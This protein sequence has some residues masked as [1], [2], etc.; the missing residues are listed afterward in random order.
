[1]KHFFEKYWPI[2]G[3]VSIVTLI[4]ITNHVPNAFLTGGDNL[5]PE[6][7]LSENIKRSI[8]SVWQEY[9]GVGLLAGMGHASD[10]LRQL[11]L[12]IF[13]AIMPVESV[14]YFYTILTLIIGSIGSYFLIFK[15]LH[16]EEHEENLLKN[17][18]V[19]ITGAVFYLLNLAT[20]QQYF[21]AFEVFTAHFAALPFLILTAVNYFQKPT[22]KNLFIAG[23]ISFLASPGDYVPTL[24]IVYLMAASIL[25]LFLGQKN[26]L[27]QTFIKLLKYLLVVF[28]VNSFW[29]LPFI[30]FVLTNSNVVTNSQINRLASQTIFEQNKEF[31]DIFD[32]M[33][34]KGFW[35]N[36]VEPNT[37]GTFVYM[38]DAWRKYFSNPFVNAIGFSFFGVIIF[39]L[40]QTFRKSKSLGI[41]F[42]SLFVFSFTMLTTAT[43]PFSWIVAIMRDHLPLF[44]EVFRFPFTKFSLL[45]GLSYSIFFSIGIKEI[46]KIAKLSKEKFYFGA[47]ALSVF[48]I[49][50]FAL[51]TFRGEFFYYREQIQIP[52]YY[53]DFFNYLNKQDPSI[54][55]SDFPQYQNWE[56]NFYDWGYS[57]S[58]FVWYGIKQPILSRTFD[59]WSTQNE[60]YYWEIT[61]AMYAKNPKLFEDVLNKYQVS[62][63]YIDNSIQSPSS[64]KGL[65][66][67]ELK[68]II[69]EDKSIK[70]EKTFG[71]IELYSHD[72]SSNQKGFIYTKSTLPKVNSYD[73]SSYDY[74][75]EDFS[76]YSSSNS[77]NG[78]IYYPFRSSLFSRK[79]TTLEDFNLT[80]NKDYLE[81]S[82]ELP[83]TKDKIKLNLPSPITKNNTLPITITAKINSDNNIEIGFTL[84]SP[85]IYL[86]KN[87]KTSLVWKSDFGQRLFEVSS[88]Q[89][90][91]VRININGANTLTLKNIDQGKTTILGTST[92]SASEDNFIVLSDNYKNP[93]DAAVVPSETIRNFFSQDNS[94][95]YLKN[96]EKNTKLMVRVPKVEDEVQGYTIN[97][98]DYQKDIRNCDNFRNGN[99]SSDIFNIN[100]DSFLK[101]SGKDSSP[102]LTIPLNTLDHDEAY[103]IFVNS[104][105]EKGRGAHFWILNDNSEYSPIETYLPDSKKVTVSPFVL[106]PMETFG[107]EYSIHLD[108]ISIGQDEDIN[109]LGKISI[110]PV[111]YYFISGISLGDNNIQGSI[112]G[113]SFDTAHPNQSLY[114]VN[115]KKTDQDFSLILSQGFNKGW[116]AYSVG[117]INLL[118]KT[119]PFI[120]GHRIKTHSMVNNWENGWEIS[121]NDNQI[122]IVFLPQYLEYIGFILVGLGFLAL[123]KLALSERI[124]RI[125]SS[126]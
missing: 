89:Q 106:E 23:L 103:A 81:F 43:P 71:S 109:D 60:N 120:F 73:S 51:P 88:D 5:H 45:A 3:L 79:G 116:Q 39:G 65:F 105:N 25:G 38:M 74:A 24:F 6:F 95:F 18:L 98:S 92:F 41:A 58:G 108:N 22:R 33:L 90:L 84:N 28:I 49:I 69:K 59:T 36:N 93:I 17:Q 99:Y 87:G 83:V 32:V 8:F 9:Q 31:G 91:P 66:K 35:F 67:N 34:L 78:S 85:S 10:L 80:E 72:L 55:I 15:I 97:P 29:L 96:I 101:V 111:P 53:F 14:R 77:L 123:V 42:L 115:F 63:L 62:K 113:P 50:I 1:M 16:E 56:W 119:F 76:D 52:H 12:G 30:Y 4:L 94:F 40:I 26:S 82:K 48:L 68:E 112:N 86:N 102:C 122:V 21:T 13:M 64:T 124:K 118:T 37:T 2:L 121:K 44:G 110:N 126:S 107:Q 61:N 104:K 75:Y 7:N 57:G 27:K 11:L 114:T 47:T 20:L 100:S 125:T 54:R 46:L 19:A 117:K 70:K